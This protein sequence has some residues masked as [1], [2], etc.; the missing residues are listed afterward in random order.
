MRIMI[1]FQPLNAAQFD[2]YR[3]YFIADYGQEI[4]LNFRVP[5]AQALVQAETALAESFPAGKAQPGH[6]LLSIEIDG[7]TKQN[8][9]AQQIGYFWLTDTEKTHTVFINDFV[10]FSELRNKGLAGVCRAGVLSAQVESKQSLNPHVFITRG[11]SA[12]LF[13][14]FRL[15]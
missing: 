13:C 5:L 2:D 9:S 4:S 7:D 6:H 8:R 10:I 3:R 12:L 15:F 1:K 14:L 11:F